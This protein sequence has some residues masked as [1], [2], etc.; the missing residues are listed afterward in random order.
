MTRALRTSPAVVVP[1][2]LVANVHTS[3]AHKLVELARQLGSEEEVEGVREGC[4]VL[5]EMVQL[6]TGGDV[7]KVLERG[8]GKVGEAL[9]GDESLPVGSVHEELVHLV[10]FMCRYW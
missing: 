4:A 1:N 6:S 8:L 5:V 3:I 2:R 7:R 10:L 9:A